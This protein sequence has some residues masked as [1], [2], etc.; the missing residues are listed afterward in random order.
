[1]N[2]PPVVSEEPPVRSLSFA[3]HCT[4]RAPADFDVMVLSASFEFGI[5]PR[6]LAAT[7]YRESGCNS[8]ALGSSGEIGLTQ[9]LPRV[10]TKR[11]IREG[12]IRTPQ[13][14]WS[15]MTSLRAG[16]YILSRLLNASAGS[17]FGAFRRYNGSGPKARRYAQSQ[18]RVV[19][20]LWPEVST[21]GV[22][23]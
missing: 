6:M 17:V 14:L 15:P 1:M 11:L 4:R 3:E 13:D 22:K 16:A 23:P 9:V 19:N 7:V 20:E 2:S 12:L 10:W 5:D 18:M 21:P 8:K